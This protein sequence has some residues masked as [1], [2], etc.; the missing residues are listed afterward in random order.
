LAVATAAARTCDAASSIAWATSS[1]VSSMFI[2][3]SLV[4]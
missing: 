1:P 4:G 2:V 3:S